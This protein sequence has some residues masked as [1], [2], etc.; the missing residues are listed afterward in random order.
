MQRCFAYRY[1]CAPHIR[2]VLLEATKGQQIAW[3]GSYRWLW[4]ALWVLG[5]EPRSSGRAASTQSHR[6]VYPSPSISSLL[7]GKSHRRSIILLCW[8]PAPD[9]R[10]HLIYK[11]VCFALVC[12]VPW[13][14]QQNETKWRV[15][16]ACS[17]WGWLLHTRDHSLP[18]RLRTI[19]PAL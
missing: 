12:D 16:A 15:W 8:C 11:Y 5:A 6:A 7:N 10:R 4:A 17:L 18:V 9:T 1:V 2:L 19:F 3:N 13:N 14:C